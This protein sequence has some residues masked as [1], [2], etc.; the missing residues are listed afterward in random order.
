M[1]G[2]E[3]RARKDRKRPLTPGHRA[4]FECEQ[5]QEY[6]CQENVVDDDGMGYASAFVIGAFEHQRAEG[7]EDC[8]E[9]R[10]Q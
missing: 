5:R 8:G 3:C 2:G 1:P 4:R 6:D 9:Q 7:K 10:E